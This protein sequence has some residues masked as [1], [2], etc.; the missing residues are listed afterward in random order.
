MMTTTMNVQMRTKRLRRAAALGVASLVVATAAASAQEQIGCLRGKPLPDC[1]TFWI[2]EMQGLIPMAQTSRMVTYS[3]D[4]TYA[5]EAKAFDNAVEWNIG[6]MVNVGDGYAAGGVFTVG[7]GNTDPLTGIRVRGRKWLAKDLSVEVEGGL[8]RTN[9]ADTHF[10]GAN[11]WTADLRLNIRDQGSFF[12][13]YDGVSL[14]EESY[15]DMNGHFD[16][17]GIH[18]GLSLGASAGSVPALVGTGALG[19]FYVV[20]FALYAGW[21]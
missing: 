1:K 10:P 11:G 15:P 2:V 19:L 7:S 8:L 6:H 16:P 14:P 3:G 18:H 17:G 5:Y 13:R 12:V 4:W 20:V 21:D 9:A